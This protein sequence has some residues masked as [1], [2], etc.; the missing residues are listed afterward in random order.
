MS[1][2]AYLPPFYQ[3]ITEMRA[4]VEEEDRSITEL[5]SLFEG[6]LPASMVHT[7]AEDRLAAWESML[8]IV[9]QGTLE[10]RRMLVIARLR[11]Q[12]KLSG[13][14]IRQIVGSFTGVTDANVVFSASTVFVR[15]YPPEGGEVFLFGDVERAIAPLLPA[16]L[17]LT[18]ERFYNTWRDRLTAFGN[19]RDF[20]AA[21]TDWAEVRNWIKGVQG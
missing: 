5:R 10:Q 20:A 19:W 4:I 11:G 12:G 7:A 3:E 8:R 2:F 13:N 21:Y 14:R 16:H 9:P 18:V 6:L 1:L 15:I 17:H